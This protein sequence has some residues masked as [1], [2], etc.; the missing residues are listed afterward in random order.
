MGWTYSHIADVLAALGSGPSPIPVVNWLGWAGAFMCMP[1]AVHYT[2]A[3]RLAF[4]S[5]QKVEC[6]DMREHVALMSC[7]QPCQEH[8]SHRH[9]DHTL[10]RDDFNLPE[11]SFIFLFPATTNRLTKAVFFVWLMIV[12][13]VDGSCLLLLNKPRR[14]RRMIMKWIQVHTANVDPDFDPTRVIFRP[15]QNKPYF[16][17]LL[18]VVGERGACIDSVDPLGPHTGANDSVSNHTP[19]LTYESECCMQARVGYEVNVEIGLL[20]ECAAKNRASFVDHAVQFRLNRP[21]RIAIPS[22]LQRSFEQG[23]NLWDTSN[24]PKAVLMILDKVH[25]SFAAAGRDWTKLV[26]ID[27]CSTQ[28]PVQLFS[29]CPEAAALGD[30][31]EK[32]RSQAAKQEEL[33]AKRLQLSPPLKEDM[34]GSALQVMEVHKKEDLCF[35]QLW[36]MGAPLL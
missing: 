34:A 33:L 4:S 23:L 31:S 24:V 25:E 8:Q 6:Q 21:L 3:G 26:D 1:Q 20:Q 12:T 9:T 28:A 18:R 7:H 35:T 27:V 16:W 15:V 14:M 19:F 13:R 32:A 36:V 10:T 17:A 30:V 29:D 2:I 22:F 11:D 5:R